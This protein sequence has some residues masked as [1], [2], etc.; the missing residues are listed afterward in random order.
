ML[1]RQ[2]IATIQNAMAELFKNAHDAYAD[3]VQADYFEDAGP[4][5]E[6]LVILRD[7]GVGM[8]RQDFEDKW[9]VLGTESKLGDGRKQQFRPPNKANR[10][11]TGEKGIGRLAIA[12]LGQ[13]VLVLSRAVRADGLHDLVVSWLHW[14][15]FELPGLNLEEIDLPVETI[16]SG[17]IPSKETIISLRERL[18]ESIQ[19]LAESHPLLDFSQLKKDIQSF[20]PD[21]QYL[22]SFFQEKDENSMSLSGDGTGTHF[23]IAPANPIIRIE[24]SAEDR[25]ND[26]SFRKLLLGFQDHVFGSST[27][28]NFKTSFR[29]WVPGALAGDE[30]LLPE[31]FF[32]GDELEN[33]SD[34]LFS[35]KIDEFGQFTG[36]VRI[37]E[38]DYPDH[39]VPWPDSKGRKTACGPFSITFAAVQGLPKETMLPPEIWNS[40][41]TKLST[42]GS[43]YLYRDGIRV[44]PYGD[45]SFDWLNVEK[46]RNLGAGYYYFSHRRLF[47]A[48]LL[49]RDENPDLEEKA[50]REG[51]QA[52]KAYRDLR[53]ILEHLFVQLA[54]DFFRK[55]GTYTEAFE[56]DKAESKRRAT[57]LERQQKKANE[58]RK[59]FSE[60]L[61]QFEGKVGANLPVAQIET[62]RDRTQRRM[63]AASHISDQDL[64]ASALIRAEQEA[65]TALSDL[66]DSYSCKKPSG[67]AIRGKLASNWKYYLSETE[68]LEV[69]LFTP[70]DKEIA[71]TLGDVAEQARLYIDQRKRL[72]ERIKIL[73]TERKKQLSEASKMA[74]ATASETRKTVSSIT[75]KA[76]LALE[77]TI[78]NIQGEMNRTPIQDM[79]PEKVEELRTQWEKELTEIEVRHRDGL[80]AAR[81]MLASLA[82]NLRSSDGEQP[83]EIMEALE[84]RML[85]LEDQ[86]EQDFEMVQMGLAVAIINHEF[87][88]S[89]KQV[90]SSLRTLGQV[91][92]RAE[93]LRPVYESIKTS[94]EHLDGHLNLFTPLQRRLHRK[95]IVIDGTSMRNYIRD[96]F[97]NRLLRHDVTLEWSD[98]FLLAEV[99]CFPSTLYPALINIIDN[100]IFWVLSSGSEHK[101][102]LDASADALVISNNG[103]TIEE[104]DREQIF[105]RGFSRKPG[106]RGLGLFISA[107]ALSSEQM[108]LTAE[109]APDGSGTAFHIFAPNLRFKNE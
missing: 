89:I 70:F 77:A 108:R 2:Q 34:H 26:H 51:L 68:R 53:A 83:A 46:R 31:T 109:A 81:D 107:K 14:G 22:E 98:S 38:N 85:D 84:E 29:R 18:L 17:E 37:Y 54:A 25:L 28:L 21:P 92:R 61:Q 5:G 55:D 1:G 20:E 49:T 43:L 57:A 9:L 66:R 12:L 72:D 75:E 50:G 69:E 106:G 88:A 47:G 71:A 48:V 45:Q 63:E 32:T 99:E 87:A 78:R 35:G 67:L 24:L 36:N 3:H 6:G 105:E 94:F 13:Q 103:P 42:L 40:I 27:K 91:S 86:A 80:M 52:N 30:Y 79:S 4:G 19:G 93:G 65:V 62:L 16:D 104:R 60:S 64:A 8:T 44:L 39:V 23:I 15:I 73:A 100:A 58:R 102:Q 101:I 41:N 96:V 7:D 90:R 97:D 10:E 11:I 76:R 33:S 74:N 56:Q 59:R 95:A 82:E